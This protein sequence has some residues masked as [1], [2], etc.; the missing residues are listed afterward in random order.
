[1][2]ILGLEQKD[3]SKPGTLA[4]R[5]LGPRA[6]PAASPANPFEIMRAG[7]YASQRHLAYGPRLKQQQFVE[8]RMIESN[9]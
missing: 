1:M 4:V 8:M 9:G 5:A 3:W 2:E 6:S 7:R